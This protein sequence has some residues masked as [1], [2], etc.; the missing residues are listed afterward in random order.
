MGVTDHCYQKMK[1]K[2]IKKRKG[3]KSSTPKPSYTGTKNLINC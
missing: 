1:K 2:I 3:G